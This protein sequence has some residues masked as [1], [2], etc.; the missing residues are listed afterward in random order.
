MKKE[1][2]ESNEEY[3]DGRWRKLSGEPKE[4]EEYFGTGSRRGTRLNITACIFIFFSGRR[5][6][7]PLLAP[8]LESH[9]LTG[10]LTG[11]PCHWPRPLVKYYKWATHL[12]S[13]L[14]DDV[15]RSFRRP[16]DQSWIK[17]H[18]NISCV[19][20]VENAKCPNCSCWR[21]LFQVL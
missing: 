13:P 16:F 5:L 21:L 2:P 15:L 7:L 1:I 9:E 19:S 17:S 14:R 3:E 11:C 18:V 8:R 4:G 10:R 20:K 12:D 6:H